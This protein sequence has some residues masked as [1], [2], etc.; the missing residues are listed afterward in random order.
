[1]KV[2]LPAPRKPDINKYNRFL[3]LLALH[4]GKLARK[5]NPP[6]SLNV[7]KHATWANT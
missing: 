3:N 4:Y 1:M 5:T 2:V 7:P 6:A